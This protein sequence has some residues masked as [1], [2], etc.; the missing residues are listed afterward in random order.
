MNATNRKRV[1]Q[2][3]ANELS[4]HGVKGQ[5]WGVRR[6]QNKDG[7]LTYAGKQ[8]ALKTQYRYDEF[9]KDTKN[10]KYYKSDGSM[11]LKGRKKALKYK[12]EY[13]RITGGK[14]LRKFSDNPTNQRKKTSGS[15]SMSNMSNE[16]IAAKI[17]RLRLEQTLA[18]L[19]P[20]TRS[21]GQKF[22]SSVGD[23]A[24]D[25][26]KKKGTQLV[27]DY[28]DKQLR[29]KLGLN[30]S[31]TSDKLKKMAQDYENRQ[32]VDKGQQYFHEGP[33]ADKKSKKSDT[34]STQ[35]SSDN[36]KSQSKSDDSPL[37]GTVEGTGKS[38]FNPNRDKDTRYYEANYR[39]IDPDTVSRGASYVSQFLLED[40]K[41]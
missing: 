27:S 39:D 34:G 5:K 30:K 36:T 38:H 26:A 13:S 40:K 3:V 32:K 19:T 2:T 23:L 18:S 16:E 37:T 31:D 20:D 15:K 41:R 28:V 29:D 21:K 1:K 14:Q 10:K 12:E 9:A 8:R 25:T 7:S 33:Y 17:E 6:Y 24:L 22:L 4:H 35:K 11:T